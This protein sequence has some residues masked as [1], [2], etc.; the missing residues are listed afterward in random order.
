MTV[1]DS[2]VALVALV[3]VT[4]E[5]GAGRMLDL[6]GSRHPGRPVRA[7][8]PRPGVGQ[9]AFMNVSPP[10]GYYPDPAAPGYLMYWDGVAWVPASR[11]AAQPAATAP[12]AAD[13]ASGRSEDTGESGGG[14]PAGAAAA[15]TPAM[16]GLAPALS[17]SG[18]RTPERPPAPIPRQ[19]GSGDA[20][21][22]PDPDGT[23]R[24]GESG[25]PP[26]GETGAVP[27]P[28]ETAPA[29]PWASELSDWATVPDLAPA[30]ARLAARTVDLIIVFVLSTVPSLPVLLAIMSRI[31]GQIRA[32]QAGTVT[33]TVYLVNRQTVGLWA[34]YAAIAFT[35]A[36]GYEIWQLT[37]WGQ[38][39]G[40][41]LVNVR[42]T[43]RE[44][45]RDPSLGQATRRWLSSCALVVVP[46]G[47]VLD[48][49]W[50]LWDQPYRQ[51]LHDKAA[52]TVVIR[53]PV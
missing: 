2:A 41:R 14:R 6:A 40:K 30:G 31:T 13:Q 36:G 29:S 51:C 26:S 38:T 44:G 49:L 9:D 15:W 5:P 3:A 21:P 37:R 11:Q 16:P 22:G 43:D 17:S 45:V 39:V 32:A 25:S 50:S 52:G 33:T 7:G 46:I 24:P 48:V 10:P 19:P 20:Q 27:L 47:A 4:V 8:R 1:L 28:W 34:L 42:V 12:A 18:P 53:E 23:T 35:V